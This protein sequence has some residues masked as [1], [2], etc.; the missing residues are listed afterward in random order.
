MTPREVEQFKKLNRVCDEV[1]AEF[2]EGSGDLIAVSNSI[3][4]VIKRRLLLVE[5]RGKQP[6]DD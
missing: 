4:E 3:R 2:F 1:A 6:A 5:E